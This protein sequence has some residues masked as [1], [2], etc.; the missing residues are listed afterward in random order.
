MHVSCFV[1][2]MLSVLPFLHVHVITLYSL[3]GG[4]TPLHLTTMKGHATCVEHLLSTPGIEVNI[5]GW[6]SWPTRS[7]MYVPYTN[8]Y[9]YS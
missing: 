7:L 2:F 3:Q 1:K 5:R 8:R 4:Y 6:V 9:M